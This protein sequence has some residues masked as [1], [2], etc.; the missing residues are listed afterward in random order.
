MI[1]VYYFDVNANE[2]ILKNIGKDYLLIDDLQRVQESLRK[3][4]ESEFI[5]LGWV[6]RY[7]FEVVL[8]R[9]DYHEDLCKN[10][11]GKPFLR[12]KSTYF[13][14]SGTSDIIAFGMHL[15]SLIG[16]DVERKRKFPGTAVKEFFHQKEWNHLMDYPEDYIRI[17][18]R[19]EAFLKCIGTGWHVKSECS[20]L[21]NCFLYQHKNYWIEDMAFL[22]DSV[23][24]I[25]YEGKEQ[26]EYCVE[27]ITVTQMSKIEKL[28]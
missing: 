8:G 2:D 28:R 16:I 15:D 27:E 24:S 13:N 25:C 4:K 26:Q 17:W 19:K 14:I 22:H 11:Y 9:Y 23:L 12:D 7:M 21:E 18:A 20:V 10:C 5:A 1:Q 3:S 6:K